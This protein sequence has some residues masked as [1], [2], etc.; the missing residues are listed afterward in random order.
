MLAFLLA[1]YSNEN[2]DIL[3]TMK[4]TLIHDIVEIDAG[5]TYCY[6]EEGY[7]TNLTENPKLQ[8][9]SSECFPKISM[10]N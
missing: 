9:E 4:M 5:D 8:R 10:R 3:K 1:E 7:K 2:I 6:D